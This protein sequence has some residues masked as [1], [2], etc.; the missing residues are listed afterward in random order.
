MDRI[1][2]FNLVH[3]FEKRSLLIAINCVAGLSIFFFGYDQGVMGG[4]N[5]TRSYAEIMGFGYYNEALGEV[6]IT[7]SLLQGGIVSSPISTLTTFALML[8]GCCLLSS[9][10]SMWCFPRRLP[11]GQIWQDQHHSY[12][13]RLDYDWGHSSM[14]CSEPQLDVLQ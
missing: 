5:T 4:V 12:C 1:S 13:C 3:R 11:G 9:R 10:Y 8:S 6:T 14:F 7:N 2:K